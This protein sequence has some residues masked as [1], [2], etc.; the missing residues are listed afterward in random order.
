MYNKFDKSITQSKPQNSQ[1]RYPVNVPP[2]QMEDMLEPQKDLTE[3][4]KDALIQKR[5]DRFGPVDNTPAAPAST[6]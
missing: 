3:A 2:I 1:L 4:E 6:T 5:K